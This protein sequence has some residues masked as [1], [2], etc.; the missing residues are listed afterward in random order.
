MLFKLLRSVFITYFGLRNLSF[1]VP[2]YPSSTAGFAVSIN[3]VTGCQNPGQIALTFDDGPGPY[4]LDLLNI[5][6]SNNVQAS[7]FLIGSQIINYPN[8]VQQQFMNGHI[9][10]DHTFTHPHLPLLNMSSFNSEISLTASLVHNITGRTPKF[11]R[12][13][14]YDYTPAQMTYVTTVDNMIVFF[15]NLDTKDYINTLTWLTTYTNTITFANPLTD[16]FIVINHDIYNTT[17]SLVNKQIQIG[18]Q[19]GFRFVTLEECIGYSAY[20]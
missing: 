11:F 20:V 5:L 8:V 9:I 3:H 19:A 12:F 10:G 17:V 1:N 18:K 15:D 2:N 6:K 7:F 16:S 4:T 13:P 14:Y